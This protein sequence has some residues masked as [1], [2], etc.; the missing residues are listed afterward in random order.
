MEKTG[1]LFKQDT[2]YLPIYLRDAMHLEA[3]SFAI[4]H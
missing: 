4:Q 1:E 2:P 3:K